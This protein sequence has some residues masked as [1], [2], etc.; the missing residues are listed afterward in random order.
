M[1]VVILGAG[2]VGFQLAQE[3]IREGND[4]EKLQNPKQE[5]K[6]TLIVRS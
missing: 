6:V 3:L 2:M 4:V 1:N 5:V